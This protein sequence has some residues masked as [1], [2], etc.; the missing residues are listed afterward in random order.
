MVYLDISTLPFDYI[1]GAS[2]WDDEAMNLD[3][4]DWEQKWGVPDE[5]QSGPSI[6]LRAVEQRRPGRLRPRAAAGQ[7]AFSL[8]EVRVKP[9]GD[10][11][12]FGGAI[13]GDG[14]EWKMTYG[15][16]SGARPIFSR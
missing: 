7:R 16:P 1:A 11:H 14:D 10:V 13:R 8:S 2:M 15:R 3:R 12:L 6:R 5:Y 4:A 9:G